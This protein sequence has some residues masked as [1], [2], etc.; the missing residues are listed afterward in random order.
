MTVAGLTLSRDDRPIVIAALFIV[1]ILVAGTVY[2]WLVSGAR[3]CCRPTICLEQFRSGP[4]S[5]SSRPG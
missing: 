3:R 4:F 2:L 1:V 5:A